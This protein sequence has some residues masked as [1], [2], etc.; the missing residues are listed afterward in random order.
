MNKYFDV[1]SPE[2]SALIE[3]AALSYAKNL[4]NAKGGNVS[5]R[6]G[7]GMIISCTNTCLRSLGE[8]SLAYVSMD[9]EVLFSTGGIKPSKEFMM[10]LAVYK[11][12]PDVNSVF[13]LHPPASTAVSAMPGEFPA[14]TESA[15]EKL[16]V[17]PKVPYAPAGS[18][19]LAN[20][21]ETIVKAGNTSLYGAL[22]EN[23][24]IIAFG[25]TPENAFN[26]AE[27]IEASA[28]NIIFKKILGL[29]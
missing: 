26:T 10:H 25:S 11:A 28:T 8:N 9:G 19:E 16:P 2:V 6:Y 4:T 13:H 21:L 14:T 1:T 12:R 3:Y 24:G 15:R 7:E 17:L 23:H 20:Y 18:I 5:V 27:L 22:L 29:L